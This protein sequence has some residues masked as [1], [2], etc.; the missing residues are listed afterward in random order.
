MATDPTDN[1]QFEEPQIPRLP[2]PLHF[3]GFPTLQVSEG[4]GGFMALYMRPSRCEPEPE[5]RIYNHHLGEREAPLLRDPGMTWNPEEPVIYL[6]KDEV[7][8]YEPALLVTA[9]GEKNSLNR[10]EPD[11]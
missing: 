9:Y 8:E 7:N 3:I 1:S 4:H 10:N 2:N 6:Y 5:G 11:T